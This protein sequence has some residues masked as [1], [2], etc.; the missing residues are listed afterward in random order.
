MPDA[1]ASLRKAGLK[2]WVLTGDKEETAINIGR[3][4][5]LLDSTMDL[6]VIRGSAEGVMEPFS[7]AEIT[8]TIRETSARRVSSERDDK[9]LALVVDGKALGE[10]FRAWSPLDGDEVAFD[11]AQSDARQLLVDAGDQCA[12]VIGCR[13]SPK[14]KRDIIKVVKDLLKDKD[15]NKATPMTLAIGDGA[16]DVSMIQE[17]HIG[18]GISGNEGM[19]AV[20]SADYAIG[21]F[22]FLKPLM[23]VHGRWNYRRVCAV[24]LYSFYKGIAYNLTLF[25][26]GFFNG[27]SGTTLYESWLGSGWNVIWTFLPII[28]L[29]AF[30]QD[31]DAETALA[32]PELY[33]VGRKSHDLNRKKMGLFVLT[34]LTHALTLFW[35]VYG[36]FYRTITAGDGTTDGIYIMGTTLNGCLQ[37]T[38]NLKIVQMTH[39]MTFWN[40]LV[41]AGAAGSW[42]L[43]V[44]GYSDVYF[45][46]QVRN[47]STPYGTP[48]AAL[49]R[50]LGH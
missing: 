20:R 9:Q 23:L 43:F 16:N 30:D 22:R 40:A 10:L 5:R 50:L 39:K 3:S 38:V 34:S 6:H 18:I 33:A 42:F 48:S 37:L 19:Q 29:G 44:L 36:T 12:A 7:L 14:Q 15:G 49:L 2:I 47:C 41:I 31:V 35:I 1:I 45:L 8:A 25:Y 32:Y 21:Q 28:F 27:S 17:A 13:V 26:F 4:C 11:A 24:I 46:S